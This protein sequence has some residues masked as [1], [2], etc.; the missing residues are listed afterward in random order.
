MDYLGS[1]AMQN[2]GRQSRNE[3]KGTDSPASRVVS[4]LNE[5]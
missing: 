2:V 1:H 5:I 4:H 3:K